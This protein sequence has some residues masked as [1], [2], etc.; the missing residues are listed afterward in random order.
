MAARSCV[1]IRHQR[2]PSPSAICQTSGEAE[3]RAEAMRLKE[4]E[5]NQPFDLELGPL[6]RVTLIQFAPRQSGN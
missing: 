5:A 3:Q 4:Q 6:M 1:F 2:Y